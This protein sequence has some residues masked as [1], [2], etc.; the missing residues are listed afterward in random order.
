MLENRSFFRVFGY[1]DPN[2]DKYPNPREE[3][4]AGVAFYFIWPQRRYV[5]YSKEGKAYYSSPTDDR[6]T[7]DPPHEIEFVN[8]SVAG[9]KPDGFVKAYPFFFFFLLYFVF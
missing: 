8:I 4:G 6:E 2:R 9:G 5:N 1:M 7:P 3:G